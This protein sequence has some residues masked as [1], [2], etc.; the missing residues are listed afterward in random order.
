VN[1]GP[2]GTRTIKFSTLYGNIYLYWGPLR[3]ILRGKSK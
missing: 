1:N 2:E 3:E